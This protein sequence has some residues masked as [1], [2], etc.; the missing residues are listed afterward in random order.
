MPSQVETTALPRAANSVATGP[1]PFRTARGAGRF[2]LDDERRDDED[3]R[4][5]WL[6]DD[7]DRELEPP[8]PEVALLRDAG[9]EDVRVAMV[10]TLSHRHTSL[11]RYTP[12]AAPR[13]S[14]R[15]RHPRRSERAGLR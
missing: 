14:G 2:V 10:M 5:V 13:R 6:P 11:M 15:G 9:G 12:D 3:F 7:R 4:R 8:L 1:G